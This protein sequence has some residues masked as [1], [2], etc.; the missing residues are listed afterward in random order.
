M[1]S[2]SLNCTDLSTNSLNGEPVP[3]VTVPL[4]PAL[5]N[6]ATLVEFC[7]PILSVN[8]QSLLQ[9]DPEFVEYSTLIPSKFASVL[10][11]TS[12]LIL[13]FVYP[14]VGMFGDVK[15]EFVLFT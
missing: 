2:K 9:V 10:E 13:M 5:P 14:F 7:Q 3:D 15:V 11:A 8:S 6:A 4:N 1:L 12:K